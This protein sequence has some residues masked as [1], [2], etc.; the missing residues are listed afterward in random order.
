MLRT[1]QALR[2]LQ[3]AVCAAAGALLALLLPGVP[4]ER[5]PELL[6]FTAL[7]TLAFRL[8]VRYAGNYIGVESAA[9][10]P[11]IL[12]LNSPGAAML[13]CIVADAI[14]KLMTRP[15]RLRLANSFDLAQLSISYAAAALFCQALHPGGA[16]WVTTAALAAGALLVFFFIN[17][18]LVFAFLE[19]SRAV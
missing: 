17:T 7:T 12:L 8:R 1:G 5:W 19:L 11:A 2:V 4:W 15:R 16:G 13:I 6:F 10:I 9:L 14:S 18:A 3:I